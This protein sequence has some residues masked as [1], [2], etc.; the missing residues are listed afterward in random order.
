MRMYLR[1]W[2][3]NTCVIMSHNPGD[4]KAEEMGDFLPL[5]YLLEYFLVY[6]KLK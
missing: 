1:C 3:K 5:C 6:F 4:N 2:Q